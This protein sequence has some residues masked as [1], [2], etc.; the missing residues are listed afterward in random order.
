MAA[1]HGRGGGYIAQ[2]GATGSNRFVAPLSA[3]FVRDYTQQLEVMAP[4][5]RSGKVGTIRRGGAGT[6][7]QQFSRPSAVYSAAASTDRSGLSAS[8]GQCD[9]SPGGQRA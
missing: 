1:V 3:L 7:D 6:H 5:G 4:G 8:S 9:R 2:G